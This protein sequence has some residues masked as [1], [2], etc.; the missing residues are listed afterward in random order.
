MTV[1]VT[2]ASGFIGRHLLEHLS[3]E[4]VEAV[5]VGSG[6]GGAARWYRREAA[7]RLEGV[8]RIFAEHR[9]TH[10]I[11]LAG[12]LPPASD[13]ELWA[14]NVGL[15]ALWLEAAARADAPPRVVV[16][17]SAA[18]LGPQQVE[19]ADE[20]H[21]TRPISAYG[22]SKLTQTRLALDWARSGR[23]PVMVARTFN[24]L[25]PGAP[26]SNLMGKVALH[27]AE[28]TEGPIQ[29]GWLGAYRDFVDARDAAQAY[30]RIAQDGTSGQVV[31]VCSGRSV[32]VREVVSSALRLHGGDVA[33]QEA[34]GR[35]GEGHVDRSCGNPGR[36]ESMGWRRRY[37]LEVSIADTI[38]A[39]REENA[40]L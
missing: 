23:L 28:G 14:A 12:R 17:G 11:H 27:L 2:G 8:E 19:V 22:L 29:T 35:H 30:W 7:S 32:L 6:S 9:P 31:H 5:A 40:R 26:R 16:V 4:G 33:L 13:P 36:A 1:V 20:S 10:L 25:G 39:A 37:T 24:L 3:S 15:G 18:E 34:E 38:D 21:P